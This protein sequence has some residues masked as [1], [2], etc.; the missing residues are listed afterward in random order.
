MI[1]FDNF[2]ESLCVFEDIAVGVAGSNQFD[3]RFEA[4]TI[5]AQACV[6]PAVTGNDGSVG[7]Q[8][9]ARE[10]G[11]RTS[12][13]AEEIDEDAFCAH[14]VLVGEDA[15]GSL[16]MQD[17]QQR[18]GGF[19]FEDRRIARE[20]AIAIDERV[21]AGI[22]ERARHVV[23]R[24]SVKRMRKRRKLPRADVACEIEDAFAAA[25][26]FEEIFVAVE[27]DVALDIL[28]GVAREAGEL[29]GHP[30]EIAEH[31]AGDGGAFFIGPVGECEAEVE[32][33]GLAKFG[34]ERVEQAH[35]ARGESAGECAWQGAE[36]FQQ[37]PDCG[38]F[39]ALSHRLLIVSKV[40]G[41][42]RAATVCI[43]L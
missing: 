41:P 10:A 8:R 37:Q 36:K 38:V 28:R 43:L 18:A 9:H 2:G 4:K 29:G 21:D 32:F 35:D 13:L 16:F 22:V 7:V 39:E 24:K 30:A 5:F 19:I 17:A 12:W 3:G 31:G 42:R 40:A 6:P 20:A 1:V 11:R 26:A 33:S 34:E 14:R 27:D 15:D 23:Q 25:L